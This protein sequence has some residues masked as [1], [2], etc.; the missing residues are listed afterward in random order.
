MGL[1]TTEEMCLAF[2][3]YYPLIDVTTCVSLPNTTHPLMD[4]WD[5]ARLPPLWIQFLV[6]ALT[7]VSDRMF[8]GN[9]TWDQDEIVEY[10]DLLKTVPQIQI[11]SDDNVSNSPVAVTNV[12]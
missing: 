3:F 7:L 1:A 4:Q 12:Y 6:V 2:L 10:E 9:S 8:E 5:Q 11:A